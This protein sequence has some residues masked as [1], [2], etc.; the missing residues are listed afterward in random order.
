MR[1]PRFFAQGRDLQS[2]KSLRA[3]AAQIGTKLEL[4]EEDLIKQLRSVLRL[5]KGQ[6][7]FLLDGDCFIYELEIERMEKDRADC[8][9]IASKK[10]E[11]KQI[12]VQLGLAMIKT[13]RFEWCIEKLSELGASEIVPVLTRHCV[14]KTETEKDAKGQARLL[15]KL[16]RWRSI[17]KEAAE[18][19]ER[20]TIPQVVKPEKIAEFLGRPRDGGTRDLQFI[21]VERK[22]SAA[23]LELLGKEI[24]KTDPRAISLINSVSLL[25][26]PEGG[27]AEEEIAA[28]Q[29]QGWQPV[30]LGRRILRSETAAIVAM[31][32]VASILDI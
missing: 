7:L 4:V 14:V 21:C 16:Q 6:K 18:Q 2:I 12:P 9:V 3:I 30:S 11:A 28:A 17:V 20:V 13:E 23:L 27:F 32:Q 25:I 22:K 31:S 24:S 8:I 5:G 19:C 10:E 15:G 29:E 1:A 26:G